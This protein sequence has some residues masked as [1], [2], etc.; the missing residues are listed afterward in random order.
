MILTTLV[1]DRFSLRERQGVCTLMR[2]LQHQRFAAADRDLGLTDGADAVFKGAFGQ[3]HQGVAA[4]CHR[5]GGDVGAALIAKRIYRCVL[6]LLI[7][8]LKALL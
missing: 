4:N 6:P 5:A 1:V 8:S 7:F 2:Q 3:G